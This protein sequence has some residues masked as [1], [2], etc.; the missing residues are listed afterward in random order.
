MSTMTASAQWID[1]ERFVAVGSGGHA[2][3]MDAD[4]LS[5]TGPGPM[6]MV[7]MALCACTATDVISILR[8]KRQPV[9]RLTVAA[10]GERAAE[11]PMVY[12]QIALEYRIG[13]AVDRK[14]AED[15]IRLSRTKYCSVSIM[16]GKSAEIT[17][18]LILEPAPAA[19]E[20]R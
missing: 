1:G 9:E 16:V 2:V 6:E 8:K 17:S 14:A 11:P 13:G 19:V 3:V 20:P 18:E 5:N 12:T 4:R 10:K 7:L 15:A